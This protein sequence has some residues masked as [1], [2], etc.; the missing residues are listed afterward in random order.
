MLSLENIYKELDFSSGDLLPVADSPNSNIRHSDWLEKG[1]WLLA[2][3]R[4]NAQKIFFVDNNPV[5]VFA[6][7]KDNDLNR[8]QAYNQAWCLARPRLLF[9]SSRGEITIYDLAQKPIDEKNKDD[10]ENLKALKTLN[11]IHNVAQ[12]LQNF[13]RDNIES[14][15]IFGDKQFENLDNRADKALIRDLKIVLEELINMEL[16]YDVAPTLIGRS[17]FIRYLEDRGILTE[18]YFYQ[19]ANNNDKWKKILQ[20]ESR[21]DTSDLNPFY[22]RILSDKDFTYALYKKLAVDFNGDMFPSVAQEENIVAQEHLSLI[23]DMLYHDAGI[24]KNL[25][26]HSYRFD[27]IPLD[28]ISSI[29]EVFYH[30]ATQKNSVSSKARQDCAFYTPPVLAEFAL[31]KVLTPEV[32]KE[33]PR[34]LDP[35]CGSGI[36]LV[37][38]FRR[39][40]RYEWY[41]KNKNLTFNELKKIIRDQIAGIEINKDAARIS[42]FSLYL[43]M[44]NYLDPPDITEQIGSGNKLPNL[45]ANDKVTENHY[46]CI[47]I[48]NAFDN[49]KIESNPILKSKFGKNCADI[50]VGN[51]PWGSLRTS[52]DSESKKRKE[53]LINWLVKNDRS[54]GDIEQS[55]AFLWRVLDFLK[56]GGQCGLLVSNG[57][58]GKIGTT[59][60]QFKQKWFK[61][62]NVKEIF[63]FSFVREYFFE[64]GISPFLYISFSNEINRDELFTYWSAKHLLNIRKNQ[65]LIFTKY[66]MHRVEQ[67]YL[68]KGSI[69]KQL[70]YGRHADVK[71]I[72]YLQKNTILE[73]FVDSEKS[74]GGL[75]IRTRDHDASILQSYKMIK[76]KR[77]SRYDDLVFED[78]PEKVTRFG[79]IKS[80]YG[81]RLLLQRGIK[82]D[83]RENKGKITARFEKDSCC[84]TNSIRGI[85][86]K[87][88]DDWKYKV[89]LGIIWSSIPRYYFFLT[90]SN[91]GI[92][93]DEIY[94]KQE[95]L[96]LPVTLD[97]E[98]ITTK[99]IISIVDSLR[100]LNNEIPNENFNVYGYKENKINELEATLD[101]AVFEL[102]N[103]DEEQKDLVR[104]F[105]D[106]TL[107]SY[108]KKDKNTGEMPALKGNDFSWIERYIHVF[109]KRWN[110]YLN[111][112]EEMKAKVHL[113]AHNNMVAIEFF[114]AISKDTLNLEPK[115]NSW[116]YILEQ[117]GD[118]LPIPMGTSKILLDSMVYVVTDT[119]IIV[120]KRN[121]K[122]FWTRSLARE[123]ADTT[124]C[125]AMVEQEENRKTS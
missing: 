96:K 106:I 70:L 91:W 79:N 81:P 74:G 59:S 28:L 122:R 57:I 108:Y 5:A 104:D 80:Y 17:I 11:K 72:K 94:F 89:L 16:S 125:K 71:F 61:S 34:V 41:Q 32:I 98:N 102:Y 20:S 66:D 100:N 117:I 120:I 90:S 69:W 112:N 60:Q 87:S 12:K 38:A 27:I 78:P 124:I 9:L 83:Q 116:G 107:P 37:E 19:I 103:L 45:V 1:E 86:L 58:L 40:V 21:I 53:T 43:S 2:G 31:S 88:P 23:K 77:F 64:G 44:L 46:H 85:K 92:W 8:I 14:G 114:P 111:R 15:K 109:A 52:K 42:A 24:Q 123:D 10:W 18:K 26:F 55:Q 33:K 30:Y 6:E 68:Q 119:G 13:H 50:V 115:N 36:F 105:I 82:Q 4:A 54:I 29:Y 118:K 99:K 49:E 51:P 95:F 7:C 35:A 65:S 75:E 113:G 3:N 22:P 47:H 84:F 93:H 56:V 76:I 121:E 97:L 25:F 63:N 48:G 67:N 39:F 62:V 101:E 110:I 73:K